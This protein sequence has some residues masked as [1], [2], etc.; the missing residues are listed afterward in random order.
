[1]RKTGC[2][3]YR[4]GTD[5][6]YVWLGGRQVFL[7]KGRA[8]KAQAHARFAELLRGELTEPSRPA[9]TVRELIEAFQAHR[10]ERIKPATLASYTAVLKPLRKELANQP[11]V[12]VEAAILEDWARRQPWSNTTQRF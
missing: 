8:N 12:T 10:K 6:W 9:F 5:S 1:M 2:P 7:A 11:A 4:Q 3:W